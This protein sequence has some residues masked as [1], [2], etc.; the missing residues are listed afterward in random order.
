MRIQGLATYPV[1]RLVLPLCLHSHTCVHLRS[2][3]NIYNIHTVDNG[4]H[5][6]AVQSLTY[7]YLQSVETFIHAPYLN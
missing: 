2:A 5:R 7:S 4:H 1:R 3:Y 6:M